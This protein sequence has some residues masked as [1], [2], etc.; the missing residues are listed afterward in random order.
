MY[1]I[2]NMCGVYNQLIIVIDLFINIII[3]IIEM[4]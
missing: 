2:C 3:I 4:N 1:K